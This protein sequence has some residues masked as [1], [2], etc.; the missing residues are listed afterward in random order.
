VQQDHK[1]IRVHKVWEEHLQEQELKEH[2][3]HKDIVVHR[4]Y[5]EHKDG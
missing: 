1:V 4:V 5:K 2:K 3:A